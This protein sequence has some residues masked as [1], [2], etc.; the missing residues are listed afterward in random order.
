MPGKYAQFVFL[1]SLSYFRML[2]ITPEGK[3]LFKLGLLSPGNKILAQCKAP[4]ISLVNQGKIFF[5]CIDY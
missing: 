4:D 1:T 2:Y 3:N 5:V